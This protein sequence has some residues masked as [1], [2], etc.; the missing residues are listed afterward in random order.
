MIDI[1]YLFI[2]YV[3]LNYLY[4]YTC[5]CAYVCICEEITLNKLNPYSSV[6]SFI[7]PYLRFKISY[8]QAFIAMVI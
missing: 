5:I 7:F 6:G 8:I 3:M 4:V 1:V 2:T